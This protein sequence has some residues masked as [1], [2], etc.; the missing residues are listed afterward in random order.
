MLI[1]HGNLGRD[2]EMHYTP[3]GQAVASFSMAE[4]RTYTNKDGD[5]IK[6]T[7]WYRVSAWGKLAEIVN[8]Y[9]KKGSK[10]LVEGRLTPDKETGGPRL[11]QKQDSSWSA[12]F[13]VTAYTVEF[14]SPVAKKEDADREEEAPF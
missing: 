12:S 10:V 3:S 4:T 13:E 7:T 8:Q 2:P 11:Y 14:L 5:K 9:L 6:E 1:V